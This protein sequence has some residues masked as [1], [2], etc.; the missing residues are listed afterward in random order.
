MLTTP[1]VT[2]RLLRYGSVISK[3]LR[4]LKVPLSESVYVE[5]K[6]LGRQ[7]ITTIGFHKRN[8]EWVK[9]TLSKN[10]DI[11]IAQ[12]DDRVLN[13]VYLADQLL[14]FRVEARPQVLRAA[15]SAQT[16]EP[17]EYK[18]HDMDINQHPTLEAPLVF[19]RVLQQLICEV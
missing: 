16:E 18:G 9:T 1:T 6:K 3:N 2:N 11:F 17:E 5:T 14:D 15:A 7:D 13:N 4:H 8:R 10:Q 19:K 12:E